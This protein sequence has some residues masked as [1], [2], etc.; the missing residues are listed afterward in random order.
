M[1]FGR[2]LSDHTEKFTLVPIIITV[3]LHNLLEPQSLIYLRVWYIPTAFQVTTY[4]LSICLVKYLLKESFPYSF[5]LHV[6]GDHDDITK[7]I[8]ARV[9]PEG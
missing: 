8:A 4:P 2:W 9:R 1:N 3:H 6:W 7:V 5:T